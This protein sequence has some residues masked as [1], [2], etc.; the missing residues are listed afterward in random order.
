[1][2]P[3][4]ST[5]LDDERVASHSLCKEEEE[6]CEHPGQCQEPQCRGGH[7]GIH[8]QADRLTAVNASSV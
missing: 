8:S 1:M 4:H 6:F 2:K 5:T 3:D 7:A